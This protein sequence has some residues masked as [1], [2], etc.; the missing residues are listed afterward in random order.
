MLIVAQNSMAD[1]GC[2]LNRTASFA[3]DPHVTRLAADIKKTL[4]RA[5]TWPDYL[6][7]SGEI[8]HALAVARFNLEVRQGIAVVGKLGRQLL[9]FFSALITSP[10]PDRRGNLED[11][12]NL[13]SDDS[14][15]AL[16]RLESEGIDDE[17]AD[18]PVDSTSPCLGGCASRT[19]DPSLCVYRSRHR[20]RI[21]ARGAVRRRPT[22]RSR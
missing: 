19:A 22:V 21:R 17:D 15:S 2:R 20:I 11:F 4:N 9:F 14:D 12:S 13:V 7:I 6:T 1:T 5:E 8:H 3:L 10:A 16:D 18:S